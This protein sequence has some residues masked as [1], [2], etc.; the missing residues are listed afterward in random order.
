M[1][2]TSLLAFITCISSPLAF[3]AEPPDWWTETSAPA[4]SSAAANNLGVAST[5]QAKWIVLRALAKLQ[6]IDATAATEIHSRLTQP[7]PKVGGGY[8]PA[9]LNFDNGSSSVDGW[10]SIQRSVL[11]VGQLKAM[12]KPFY[13]E[14][15][16]KDS[17]WLASQL[18]QNET[19]DLAAPGNY[20]PWSD[21]TADDENKAPATVGQLKAVLSLRFETLAATPGDG[22]L[23]ADLD[24]LTNLQEYN[25]GTNPWLS[26]TDGDGMSDKWEVDN[27]LLGFSG[28]GVNGGQGDKDGDGSSNLQEYYGSSNPGNASDKPKGMIV[29]GAGHCMALTSEGRLWA[30][31]YNT[32]GELGDGTSTARNTPGPVQRVAGMGK[33]VHV[34][35]FENWSMA[36]DDSGVLWG[37]GRNWENQ[38]DNSD[39]SQHFSPVRIALPE[40]VSRMACG[41]NHGL[42][43]DRRGNLWAWG[44]NSNGQLGLGHVDETKGFVKVPKPPTMGEIV[45]VA[46]GSTSSYAIDAAGKVW[47]WGDNSYGQLG[48]GTI[49]PRSS[50]AAVSLGTGLPPVKFISP[51]DRHAMVLASDSTVWGWGRNSDGQ[52]G[53]GTTTSSNSPTKITSGLTTAQSV[54]AGGFHGLGILAGSVWGWGYNG[55]GQLGRDSTSSGS[56]PLQTFSVPDWSSLVAVSARSSHSMALKSDGS[57]WAWGANG[58][59]QLGLG[60][61]T[62]RLVAT[63]IPLLKLANDDSDSDSLPDS[64]EK[65]YFAG[66]LLQTASGVAVTNGVTNLVAYTFGLKP[67]IID[68]DSDG[69]TDAAEIAAGLD[70][71][72]WSDASGDLDGD[73]I[74]NLWESAMGSSMSNAASKP[75]I[76]ATVA[77]GQS[78]QTAINAVPSNSGNPTWAVIQVEPG[79]YNGN[80]IFSSGKRILLVATG[81]SQPPEIR[82]TN[83]NIAVLFSGEGVMDGFRVTHVKNEKGNGVYVGMGNPLAVARIVNCVISDHLGVTGGA[84]RVGAG[85]AVMAHCTVYGNKTTDNGSGL[86]VDSNHRALLVNSIFRNTSGIADKEVYSSGVTESIRSFVSDGSVSGAWT[87]DPL[88][89]PMGFAR[90]ISAGRA[91]GMPVGGALRDIQGELRSTKP[92]IGADQFVDG[93]RDGLPDWIENLG[94]TLP[95]G[96]ND[97]DGLPNLAE[98]ESFSFDPLVTDTLGNGSGDYYNAVFGQVTSPWYPS[99][100]RLDSDGDGLTDGQELYYGTS[101]DNADTNG[102]GVSDRVAIHSGISATS[103]DTDGDGVSNTQEL[104]NGTNPLLSDTDGDGHSDFIDKFPLDP[105]RYQLPSGTPGD[106]TPPQIQL[107]TPENATPI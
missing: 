103:P 12:A 87:H 34:A 81:S 17:V 68:N 23:D 90:A 106:T 16:G 30:W 100:W 88:L 43:V 31:G 33:L 77:V 75:A 91:R 55:Y 46:A 21:T 52:L 6:T 3:A 58:Y 82:G 41:V 73:R 48:D 85:R 20:Y 101:P 56:V 7:Q 36:L 84:I 37:W 94:V 9:V 28:T 63:K 47:S 54:T 44:E 45:F 93:D 60:D 26:D 96:D 69:L 38:I 80:I 62:Q 27:G 5:G 11:M 66:S 95:N 59:G 107:I 10:N 65:F 39:C 102:D 74:P 8:Y 72:D 1:R 32:Y 76:T 25:N 70:P 105:T 57:I 15:Q 71:L 97:S 104:L 83:N 67:T 14:L 86:Y 22:A 35:G 4:L 78:I 98:Y 99:H 89:T 24:G 51:G 79:L 13:D 2:S 40:P 92:D 49:I 42:A 19:K 18:T 53:N 61:S 64:W 50:P 29:A